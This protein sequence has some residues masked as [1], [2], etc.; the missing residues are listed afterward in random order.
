VVVDPYGGAHAGNQLENPNRERGR[1][2]IRSAV[3]YVEAWFY[4]IVKGVW[5]R[6]VTGSDTDGRVVLE[7]NTNVSATCIREHGYRSHGYYM[8]HAAGRV[9]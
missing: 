8:P 3:G 2:S 6:T 4:I 5:A 1:R 9:G 7:S